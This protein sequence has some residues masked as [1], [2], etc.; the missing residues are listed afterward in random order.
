VTRTAGSTTAIMASVAS[1]SSPPF[2]KIAEAHG[3][4]G[5][6]VEKPAELP[7]VLAAA[8]RAVVNEKRHALVNVVTPY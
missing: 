2:E 4:F 5:A 8:R 3:A 1:S 6:R 7:Q